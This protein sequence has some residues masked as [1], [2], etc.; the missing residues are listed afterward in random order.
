MA[1]RAGDRRDRWKAI[2]ATAAVNLLLGAV[3][4]TGLNVEI[5]SRAV[6]R[7]ETFDISLPKPPP[8]KPPPPPPP[9]ARDEQTEGAPAAPKASPI[10]APNPV[11]ELPPQNPVPA[12]PVAGTGS[13]SSTGQGGAGSGTGAG[14]SGAGSGRGSGFTPAQRISKVPDR[15]YRRFVSVSGLKRGSVGLTVKVN[16]D[17]RPSNCRIVRSSGSQA[18]DTLMCELTLRYVRFRPARDPQGQ[19]VAQDISWFPDWAPR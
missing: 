2:A 5:V 6:E 12:A 16:T 4:L 10:V 14:G 3:I 17:G 9:K 1:Y 7:L 19:P 13:S 18:A 11:I 15:E 8:E